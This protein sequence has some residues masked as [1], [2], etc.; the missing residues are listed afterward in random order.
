[1]SSMMP[2]RHIFEKP[3]SSTSSLNQKNKNTEGLWNSEYRPALI[4]L[5]FR[6]FLHSQRS[7]LVRRLDSRTV[8][9]VRRVCRK[10]WTWTMAHHD[11]KK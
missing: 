3:L 8:L 5:E 1:M 10:Q 4:Y 2:L 9:V 11:D 7:P 6:R